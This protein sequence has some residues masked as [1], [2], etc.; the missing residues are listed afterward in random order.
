MIEKHVLTEHRAARGLMREKWRRCFMLP[1]YTPRR[2]W[3]CDVFELTAAGYFVEYEIKVS[4]A[5][6]RR[7]SEKAR[8]PFAW[9]DYQRGR[10][11]PPGVKKH[12]LLASG[13]TLGPCRFY[14]VTPPG[15]L[16]NET[17]PSWAGHLEMHHNPLYNIWQPRTVV[18][19]PQLHS[20]K[21]PEDRAAHARGI[22]YYRMHEA[23]Q[24]S[25][26]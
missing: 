15:L 3:E 2:W 13:S 19:A 20:E 24:R 7:D 16:E 8:Q 12:E 21:F 1:N 5:D 10:A 18:K 23:F 25:P 11:A 6:F 14:F 9:W 17:L 4:I 26:A 22:C